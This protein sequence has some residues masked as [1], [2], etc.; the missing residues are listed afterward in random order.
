MFLTKNLLAGELRLHVTHPY[1][2]G[3][4]WWHAEFLFF[5]GDIEYREDGGDQDRVSVNAGER[6]I[7]LDFINQ[8]GKID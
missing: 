2:S 7:T 3:P 4:D 8:T 1:I 6:T 5:D